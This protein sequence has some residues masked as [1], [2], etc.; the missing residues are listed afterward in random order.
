M[1]RDFLMKLVHAF[2]ILYLLSVSLLLKGENKSCPQRILSLSAAA[3]HILTQLGHPPAAIDKYGKIAA[4][5][6]T[7][8]II[9]KGSALSQEKLTELA[10]DCVILWYYQNA[11]AELFKRKGLRIEKIP[12]IR[13]ANY[14][15]LIIKLGALI[16]RSKKAE[17]FCNDFKNKLKKI[18]KT[19]VE[20]K[21]RRVYLELYSKG[22][23]AGN[24][25]YAGDLVRAAG[26]CC[27]NKKTG[28]LSIETVIENAPEVIFYIKG[29][30]T[31]D[32]I[33]SRPGFANTPAVKNGRVYPLERKM[34]T[35]GLAPLEAIK[36][37]KSCMR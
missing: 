10:I 27:I 16:N 3:T 12:A 7:P 20:E 2:A 6:K 24:D 5:K 22:K 13:L 17:I 25:S 14:P 18:T 1:G 23:C 33:A 30:G 4:G 21:P 8:P 31:P 28:L 19:T 26:G 34:I 15:L 36:Y 35:A 11:T 9:G 29:F 37:L 32:E